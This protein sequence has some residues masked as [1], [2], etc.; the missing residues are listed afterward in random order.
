MNPEETKAFE[1]KIHA[2]V[3]K[4]NGPPK[5]GNDAVNEPMIRQW[6][7]VMGDESPVYTDKKAA[8]KSGKGGIIAPPRHVASLVNGGLS[9]GGSTRSRFAAQLA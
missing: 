2:F 7:E 3:G 9:H 8:E 1:Q 4:E 5:K 6:A